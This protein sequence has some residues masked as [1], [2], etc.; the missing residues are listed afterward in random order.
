[1]KLAQI[2]VGHDNNFNLIRFI[3]AYAVLVSHSF[4]LALGIGVYEPFEHIGYSLGGIAVDVFFLTSGFL[5]TA[6]L[7]R[8]Q[9]NRAFFSARAWRI[10]PALA[11]MA[12]LLALVIGPLVTS[13]PLAEYF[14]HRRT[15]QFISNNILLLFGLSY[16][17]PG[18]FDGLPVAGVVNGSLW[19]LPL[20]VKCYLSLMLLWW[21]A[22]RLHLARPAFVQRATL[23]IVPVCLVSF[24]IVRAGLP[25]PTLSWLKAHRMDWVTDWHNYRLFFMYFC[26]AAY[27]QLRERVPMNLPLLSAAMAAMVAAV[28]WPTLFFWLYPL[29][30][31]YL[32]LYAAY[33]P[34][35]WLLNFNRLGDYSYGTYIYAWPMQQLVLTALGGAK[36]WQVMGLASIGT[37]LMAVLSWH[38]VEQP[39]LARKKRALRRLAPGAAPA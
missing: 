35:G 16:R 1:M 24:W 32:V 38:F 36:P 18:V 17:L 8:L 10:L 27:Y 4:P 15:Y 25:A 2:A 13:L 19:T 30:I 22:T 20:E 7:L 6:S 37:L 14:S 12:V 33:V 11:A 21:M 5:V 39:A 9:D 26:G 23:V 34:K 3:A 31:G 29:A 28:V